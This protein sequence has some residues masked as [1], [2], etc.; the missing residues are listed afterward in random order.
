MR[1]ILKHTYL[2]FKLTHL[3]IQPTNIFLRDFAWFAVIILRL[4]S[5]NGAVFGG[6]F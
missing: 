1:N 6:V 2:G 3:R 5:E 4:L